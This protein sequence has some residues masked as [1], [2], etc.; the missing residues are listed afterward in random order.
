MLSGR[1]ILSA[2]LE[3]SRADVLSLNDSIRFDRDKT[4]E[5]IKHKAFL[6]RRSSNQSLLDKENKQRPFDFEAVKLQVNFWT[7]KKIL[8]MKL[9]VIVVLSVALVHN[10]KA[11]TI[12]SAE[13]MGDGKEET[14]PAKEGDHFGLFGATA[15]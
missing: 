7:T 8:T 2:A 4:C 15:V 11:F 3:W 6:Q 9:A 10:V 12:S 13:V 1:I 14:R 5:S